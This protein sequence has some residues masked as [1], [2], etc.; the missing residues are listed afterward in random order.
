VAKMLNKYINNLSLRSKLILFLVI[1]IITIL[2]FSGSSILLKFNEQQ[3]GKKSLEF[4]L[5]SFQV[6][7]VLHELQK[8]RGISAGF[9]GSKGR[10][11]REE[12]LAQRRLTD[13]KILIFSNNLNA[14]IKK[15]KYP[16]LSEI[17]S[18]AKINKKKLASIRKDVEQ[19]YKLDFF[20]SYSDLISSGLNI[21]RHFQVITS[22]IVLARQ[23]DAYTNLLW[24]QERAGQ[25]RGLLNGIFALGKIDATR[26]KFIA[27]YISEQESLLKEFYSIASEYQKEILKDKMQDPRIT[28]VLKLRTAAVHK[29]TRNDRLNS[30][31]SL[32]GYGGLIHNFKNYVIRGDERYAND[33]KLN[34]REAI[35]IIND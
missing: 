24:L 15:N 32:I 18:R 1:P 21:I 31:Q 28:D 13:E 35:Q 22:D 5:I 8:E 12:M 25:E 10:L 3:E 34:Y 2:Y 11:L 19:T 17:V 7:D 30:L 27:G 33:F 9:I 16:R 29:A 14:Q 26:F 23:S 4:I 6:D 20:E